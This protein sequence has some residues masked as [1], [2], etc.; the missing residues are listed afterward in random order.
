[1]LVCHGAQDSVLPSSQYSRLFQGDP[2]IGRTYQ[3]H[4]Y[5][6]LDCSK[7]WVP[8]DGIRVLYPEGMYQPW[9]LTILCEEPDYSI[10][11]LYGG[12]TKALRLPDPTLALYSYHQLTLQLAQIVTPQ[13]SKIWDAT[14]IH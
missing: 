7:S 9:A 2:Y 6:H 10:S 11:M 5:G 4:I 1:V 8:G 3:V 14:K 13:N 12:G